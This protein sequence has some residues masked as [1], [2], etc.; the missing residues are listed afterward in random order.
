MKRV[1]TKTRALQ[2]S[3]RFGSLGKTETDACRH[4]GS[5]SRAEMPRSRDGA[6]AR[7]GSGPHLDVACVDFMATT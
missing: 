2:Q 6:T 7:G 1:R 3:V 5:G 4:T